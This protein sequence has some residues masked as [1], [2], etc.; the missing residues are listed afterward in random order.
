MV[1]TSWPMSFAWIARPM[2]HFLLLK[3]V[4]RSNVACLRLDCT[5]LCLR[6]PTCTLV[7]RALRLVLP[8]TPSVACQREQQ[9]MISTVRGMP[10]SRHPWIASTSTIALL[11]VRRAEV[12]GSALIT[13]IPLAFIWT[14]TTVIATAASSRVSRTVGTCAPTSTIAQHRTRVLLG[15]AT[16]RSITTIASARVA[17]TQ[18]ARPTRPAPEMCVGPRRPAAIPHSSRRGS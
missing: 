2:V 1:L 9:L 5:R 14:I 8:D 16:I 6:L 13:T 10:V 3:A 4:V 18:K 12:T 17:T 11:S 15:L 7:I